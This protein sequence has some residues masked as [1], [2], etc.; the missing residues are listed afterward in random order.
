MGRASLPLAS[1][2]SA[3]GSEPDIP[4]VMPST[5][6][7]RLR[8]LRVVLLGALARRAFPGVRVSDSVLRVAGDQP[9]LELGLAL[10]ERASAAGGDGA[11]LG[12]P[13]VLRRV[14]NAVRR[15]V[16]WVGRLFGLRQ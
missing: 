1:S 10:I 13:R 9:T 7:R 5:A 11:R 4:S 3:T 12:A 6:D 16:A 8:A 14:T 15:A 2:H